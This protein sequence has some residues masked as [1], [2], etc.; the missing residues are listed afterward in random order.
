MAATVRGAGQSGGYNA[1][2]G[3]A[4]LYIDVSDVVQTM[5]KLSLIMRQDN[6]QEMMRRTFVD[7]GRKVK[8]I[9]RQE[10]PKEYQVTAGWAG[11]H[12]G[13]MQLQSLGVVI[14]LKG[15]RGSDGG[16]F[17]ATGGQYAVKASTVHMKDGTVRSRKASWRSRKIKVGLVR[18]T[19][20]QLPATMDHQ[21]G[22]PPFMRG[23]VVFTRKTKKRYPIVSVVGLGLPQMPINR[24]EESV[25]KQISEYTMKRLEHHFY[26]LF[27]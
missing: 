15:A 21:G 20:S 22:Q 1:N 8:T 17:K 7:A 5:E 9:I 4:G 13:S 3:G 26:Q 24:S 23:G 19:M 27:G 14:P 18:G 11:K 25:Q 16:T 2:Y 6:F 10:V 12:V